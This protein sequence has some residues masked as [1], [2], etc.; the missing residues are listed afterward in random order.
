MGVQ[1]SGKGKKKDKEEVLPGIPAPD[2]SH[3]DTAQRRAY[4]FQTKKD[5]IAAMRLELASLELQLISTLQ[6]SGEP[7][8][9]VLGRVYRLNVRPESRKI[10]ILSSE[11]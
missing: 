4:D 9:K 3:F 1:T 11:E 10:R 8:C 5:E 2:I 7:E 6:T